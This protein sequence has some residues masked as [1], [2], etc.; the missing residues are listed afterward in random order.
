MGPLTDT[1]VVQP[2]PLVV[3][4]IHFHPL[5]PGAALATDFEFVEL[6]NRGS[7]A[8]ILTGYQVRG[9]IEFEFTATN[10]VRELAPGARV[11]LVRRHAQFVTRYPNSAPLIAGEYLGA[12]SNGGN[13]LALFGPVEEPGF[14]FSYD[15]RWEPF[16][17]GVGY[18]L[19]LRDEATA[20]EN[21][22][23]RAAWRASALVD[24]SP[25]FPD[26]ASAHPVLR[27]NVAQVSP[28]GIRLQFFAATG[29]NYAVEAASTVTAPNWQI[30]ALESG[31]PF[32]SVEVL[33]PE[34]GAVQFV[35]LREP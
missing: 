35:R 12:L 19:V 14:D 15:D 22:G 34:N 9:G 1:F 30:V 7:D 21:L 23:Q 32:R 8:V 31:G 10:A 18:S 11:L 24:G 4:E 27:V 20:N 29:H 16:A 5:A 6:L 26:E 25:G 28:A 17:D 33:L 13:R 3:S 2:L